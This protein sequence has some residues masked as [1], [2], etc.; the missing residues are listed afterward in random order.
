MDGL[1]ANICKGVDFK[2]VTLHSFDW[3]L[4]CSNEAFRDIDVELTP[5]GIERCDINKGGCQPC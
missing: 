4:S 3:R 5:V 2:G 1:P